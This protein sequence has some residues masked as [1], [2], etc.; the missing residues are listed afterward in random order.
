MLTDFKQWLEG[1][2]GYQLESSKRATDTWSHCC[3]EFMKHAIVSHV[4]D[5]SY[6]YIQSF[7]FE[8]RK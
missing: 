8:V 4:L 3:H 6:H 7:V 1:F 2:I 5:F